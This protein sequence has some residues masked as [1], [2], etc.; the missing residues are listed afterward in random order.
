MQLNASGKSSRMWEARHN[1]KSV[2]NN[3]LSSGKILGVAML[4]S[5]IPH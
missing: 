4:Q 3:S 5:F 2:E 1:V